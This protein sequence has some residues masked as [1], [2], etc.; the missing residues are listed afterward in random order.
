MTDHKS[1]IQMDARTAWWNGG[2]PTI[3]KDFERLWLNSIEGGFALTIDQY[4][5]Y[6]DALVG[7]NS[8]GFKELPDKKTVK[9]SFKANIAKLSSVSFGLRNEE[10]NKLVRIQGFEIEYAADFDPSEPRR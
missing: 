2:A 7:S 8:I 6:L 10:K 1:A 4:G 3:D 9:N 5:N